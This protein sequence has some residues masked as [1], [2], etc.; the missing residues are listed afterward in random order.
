M[1]G[2]SRVTGDEAGAG[3]RLE[4]LERAHPVDDELDADDEDQEAHD[5]HDRADSGG[6]QLVDPGR[7][8][9]QQQRDDGGS[10]RDS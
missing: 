5:A 7:P 4:E 8:V 3:F 6:T 1:R 9:A 10:Y 2:L